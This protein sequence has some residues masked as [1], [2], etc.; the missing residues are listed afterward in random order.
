MKRGFKKYC[1]DLTH[2][3]VSGF[4]ETKGKRSSRQTHA[5]GQI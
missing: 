1:L 2:E 3:D 4:L 5:E